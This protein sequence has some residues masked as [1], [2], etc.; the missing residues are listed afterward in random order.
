MES[1]AAIANRDARHI[2]GRGRGDAGE[3]CV[4]AVCAPAPSLRSPV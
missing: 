3:A 2:A 4:R 1:L